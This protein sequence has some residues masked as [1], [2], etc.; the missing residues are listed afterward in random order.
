MKLNEGRTRFDESRKESRFAQFIF[1][2]YVP[3]NFM[4]HLVRRWRAPERAPAGAALGSDRGLR[5]VLSSWC[6]SEGAWKGRG[7]LQVRGGRTH[8][9]P[10]SKDKMTKEPVSFI[11][12]FCYCNFKNNAFSL[13]YLGFLLE[14]WLLGIQVLSIHGETELLHRRDWSS[15][16]K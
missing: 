15:D 10:H 4:P 8:Q 13:V 1:R 3:K 5:G 9:Q 7:S 12:T 11:T 14:R 2:L 6:C 16:R